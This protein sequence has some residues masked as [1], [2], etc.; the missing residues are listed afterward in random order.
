MFVY[1]LQWHRSE[2]HSPMTLVTAEKKIRDDFGRWLEANA[3]E[4]YEDVS[5]VTPFHIMAWTNDMQERG[6]KDTSVRTKW[7]AAQGLFS[8]CE[9]WGILGKDASPFRTF[10]KPPKVAKVTKPTPRPEDL[11]KMLALCPHGNFL[12]LR[13]RAMLLLFATC[14]LRRSELANIKIADV[15][16][17]HGRIRI[18][19]KG[20]K[21]RHVSIKQPTDKALFRYLAQRKDRCPW[22]WV[23]NKG[24]RVGYHGIASEMERIEE[25]AG[26]TIR[27]ASHAWRRYFAVESSKAGISSRYIMYEA[28]WESEAMLTRYTRSMADAEAAAEAYRERNPFR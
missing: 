28:G 11:D 1:Y 20:A 4:A 22:L 2:G 10:R 9:E 23:N 3:P 25:R 26:V 15:D 13:R 5:L 8:W 18:M 24:E 6:N 14:G 12:G 17:E 27:D 19:G 21:E 16:L 7:V